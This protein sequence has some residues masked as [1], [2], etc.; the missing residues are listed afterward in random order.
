MVE[1]WERFS[2]YGVVTLLVPYLTRWEVRRGKATN[3]DIVHAFPIE[4]ATNCD[5]IEGHRRAA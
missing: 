4:D 3:D 5:G 2:F 1:M